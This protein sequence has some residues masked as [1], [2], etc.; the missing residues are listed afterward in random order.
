LRACLDGKRVSTDTDGGMRI[1]TEKERGR[2]EP[3]MENGKQKR[4]G[5][6]DIVTQQLTVNM[7]VKERGKGKGKSRKVQRV[8]S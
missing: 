6:Q 5:C 8:I 7:I 3:E 4:Y 2:A 1:R